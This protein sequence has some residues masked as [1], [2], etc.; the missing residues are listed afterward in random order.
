MRISFAAAAT[1]ALLTVTG[2]GPKEG[3]TVEKTEAFK[4]N[5]VTEIIPVFSGKDV[6]DIAQTTA[7]YPNLTEKD[8]AFIIT[9]ATTKT[10]ER[11]KDGTPLC[12]S[13]NLE[14]CSQ[15]ARERASLRAAAS[16]APTS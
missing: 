3:Q 2:C 11:D 10:L 15:L 7:I 16:P 14:P 6:M 1:A 13:V 8:F 4:G 9:D 12:K 5:V